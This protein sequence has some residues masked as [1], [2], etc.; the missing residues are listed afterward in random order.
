MAVMG[1]QLKPNSILKFALWLTPLRLSLTL[2]SGQ[3]PAPPFCQ[4]DI[5]NMLP[6]QSIGSIA[7]RRL[8]SEIGFGLIELIILITHNWYK[9]SLFYTVPNFTTS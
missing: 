4:A 8:V 3:S 2:M 6:L 5:V 9:I 7:Y 1:W